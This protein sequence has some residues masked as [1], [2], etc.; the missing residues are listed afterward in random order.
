MRTAAAGR[1]TPRMRFRWSVAA[2]IKAPVGPADTTPSA[3]PSFTARVAW[4]NDASSRAR[5]ARAGSSSFVMA[6]G[7]ST[8]SSPPPISAAGPKIVTGTPDSRPPCATVAAPLSAPFASS[9]ITAAAL[10]VEL[11]SRLCD[12][13][14]TLVVAAVRA[15][16]V[17]QLLLVALGARVRA[18]ERELVLRAA[19]VGARVRLLLLRD[20]H[21]PRQCSGA[22][23]PARGG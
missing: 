19:L 8:T 12:Y 17:G 7:A 6:T 20:G 3:R 23:R 18:A 10:F 5:T 16:P 2:A 9:A 15:H 13:L 1:C 11:G 4:T 21:R 14:A 22:I